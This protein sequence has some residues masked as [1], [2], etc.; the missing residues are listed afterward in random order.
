[1]SENLHTPFGLPNE[2]DHELTMSNLEGELD[3]LENQMDGKS[4]GS[5][6]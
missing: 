3:H 5:F 1:M 4:E 2:V 6:Y